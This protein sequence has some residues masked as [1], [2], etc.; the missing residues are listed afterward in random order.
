MFSQQ[1]G[2]HKIRLVTFRARKGFHGGTTTHD[3]S[4][5]A[6]VSR[7]VIFRGQGEVDAQV[8]LDTDGRLTPFN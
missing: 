6:G 1:E 4:R 3:L 7:R 5:R 2:F 8:K